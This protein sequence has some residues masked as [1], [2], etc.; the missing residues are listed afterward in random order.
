MRQVRDGAAAL[1]LTCGVVW[2]P[3]G[4]RRAPGSGQAAAPLRSVCAPPAPR[5]LCPAVPAT[6]LALARSPAA[7]HNSK[8]MVLECGVSRH[9]CRSRGLM[10]QSPSTCVLVAPDQGKFTRAEQFSR[11]CQPLFFCTTV[12]CCLVLKGL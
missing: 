9:C 10:L 8:V 12:Y 1:A 6:N 7:S 3:Q 5:R 4:R 11:S 2:R